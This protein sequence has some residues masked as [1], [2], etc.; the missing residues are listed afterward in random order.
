MYD[1]QAVN[2]TKMFRRAECGWNFV[3]FDV[4]ER[5]ERVEWRDGGAVMGFAKSVFRESALPIC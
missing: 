1:C 2:R 3:G 5:G 4:L